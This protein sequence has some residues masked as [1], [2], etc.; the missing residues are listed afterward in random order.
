VEIKK[1][2]R[3]DNKFLLFFVNNPIEYIEKQAYQNSQKV[4]LDY[5]NIFGTPLCLTAKSLSCS[6]DELQGLIERRLNLYKKNML[7]A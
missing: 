5:Q 1:K 4:L 7:D 3:S 6:F 2:R